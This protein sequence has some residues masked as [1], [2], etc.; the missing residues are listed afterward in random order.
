MAAIFAL[1]LLGGAIPTIHASP[2]TPQAQAKMDQAI[3]LSWSGQEH[4]C[5]PANARITVTIL[6]PSEGRPDKYDVNGSLCAARQIEAI[7]RFL[8]SP[9]AQFRQVQEPTR[10]I[11][12]VRLVIPE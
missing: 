5:L 9:R 3:N 1:M 12:S 11:F 6:V 2:L 4:E 7:D 8:L 10:F